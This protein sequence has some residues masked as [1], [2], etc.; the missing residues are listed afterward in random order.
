M[1]AEFSVCSVSPTCSVCSVCFSKRFRRV[2]YARFWAG[3]YSDFLRQIRCIPYGPQRWG[4][5]P[6]AHPGRLFSTAAMRL[7]CCRSG[8][9]PVLSSTSRQT[10]L[11]QIEVRCWV[12]AAGSAGPFSHQQ[13]RSSMVRLAQSRG[14]GLSRKSRMLPSQGSRSVCA[15]CS[16]RAAYCSSSRRISSSPA[17]NRAT[18]SAHN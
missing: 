5:L 9:F 10:S 4:Y 8:A 11:T 2:L 7:D 18:A 1:F 12:A 14:R 6:G 3:N 15:C 13:T 16:A 17:L